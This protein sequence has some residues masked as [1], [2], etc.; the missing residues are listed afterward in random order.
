MQSSASIRIAPFFIQP[1]KIAVLFASHQINIMVCIIPETCF[2][3]PMGRKTD[4]NNPK[5]LA[6]FAEF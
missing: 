1:V 2:T 5:M 4:T 3:N 6:V